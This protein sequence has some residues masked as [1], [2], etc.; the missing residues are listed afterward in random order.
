MSWPLLEV[1]I[2][3]D[4]IGRRYCYDQGK[5]VKCPPSAAG[6]ATK[7]PRKAKAD[8]KQAVSVQH[9]PDKPGAAQPAARPAPSAP[10]APAYTPGVPRA[11]NRLNS[12][13]QTS[14]EH[15]NFDYLFQDG[16][17]Q[18]DRGWF[19]SQASP[20]TK[21]T[22]QAAHREVSTRV[23]REAARRI[24]KH[25][26]AIGVYPSHDELVHRAYSPGAIKAA[27]QKGN[28][29]RQVLDKFRG[30]GEYREASRQLIEEVL[31]SG[32]TI[33]GAYVPSVNT[34]HL[35]GLESYEKI[36]KQWAGTSELMGANPTG[37]D[38]ARH[39]YAHELGHAIDGPD[40]E[41]SNSAEWRSAWRIEVDFSG[42]KGPNLTNYARSNP[43]EGFAEF[44]RLVYS[45]DADAGEIQSKFPGCTKFLKDRRLWPYAT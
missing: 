13:A 37:A 12:D 7:P 4:R 1:T 6:A 45:G 8:P 21:R 18:F 23:T 10:I 24:T 44:C 39:T 28:L 42:G 33:A 26:G 43:S 41:L 20:E 30:D 16:L 25:V 29:A 32:N 36:A 19:A 17:R 9:V 5:R 38:V 22:F 2:K 11:K 34:L 35:D 40:S 3:T 27:V 31:R 14:R 15:V